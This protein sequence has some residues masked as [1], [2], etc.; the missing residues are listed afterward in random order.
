MRPQVFEFDVPVVL[1]GCILLASLFFGTSALAQDASINDAVE[2]L[3]EGQYERGLEQLERMDESVDPRVDYYRGYA[4]EKL[5]ECGDAK[6]A[7]ERAAQRASNEQLRGVAEDA[8]SGLDGRCTPSAA[9]QAATPP[10]QSVSQTSPASTASS[11]L[12]RGAGRVGWKVFGWTTAILGGVVLTAVPVKSALEDQAFDRTTPYFEERYGCA[13]DGGSVN[14]GTSCDKAA[15]SDDPVYEAYQKN[16]EAA[17][18]AEHFML[19]SGTALAG[20][21]VATL[22]TVALTR[23]SAPVQWSVSPTRGGVQAGAVLRF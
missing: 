8:L 19:I 12:P 4:L 14:N 11:Q 9:T 1:A 20:A 21:G 2:L 23:P 17:E 22:V 10:N 5:G 15:L 7:Y 6:A 13:V 16:R 3:R 18:T